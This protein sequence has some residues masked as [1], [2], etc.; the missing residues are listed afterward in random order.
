MDASAADRRGCPRV[1]VIGV[2]NPYRRDDAAARLAVRRLRDGAP[3]EISV[4]EFDGEG[5]SLLAAWQEADLV[6][7]LDAV[8]SGAPPGTVRRF[9]AADGPLPAAVLRDST[10]AVGVP[11]AVELARALGRLPARLIVY[12]IE[13]ADFAAGEGLSPDVERGLD[14]L[15]ARILD[16]IRSEGGRRADA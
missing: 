12:G 8:S 5:T 15:I 9:D 16:D 6:I 13:G 2:G 3:E 10:H 11:E 14:I 1:L 4:R 7:V